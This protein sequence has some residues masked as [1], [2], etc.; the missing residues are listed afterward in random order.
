MRLNQLLQTPDFIP[1]IKRSR[2]FMQGY[3]AMVESYIC[4]KPFT[5]PYAAGNAQADAF[6][7]GMQYAY[8]VLTHK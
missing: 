6:A 7:Y 3:L 5:Y 2:E 8:F 1:C 4:L